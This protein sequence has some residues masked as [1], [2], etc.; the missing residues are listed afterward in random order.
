MR[1]C[2]CRRAC[3][4][5]SAIFCCFFFGLFSVENDNKEY[6]NNNKAGFVTFAEIIFGIVQIRLDEHQ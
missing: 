3:V 5:V 4:C 1:Q 2:M 6:V